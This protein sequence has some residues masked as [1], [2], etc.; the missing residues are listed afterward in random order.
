MKF[1]WF[2]NICILYIPVSLIGWIIMLV[3]IFLAIRVFLHID[4]RS[5]SAS[6][7]L[8]NFIF[9]LAIIVAVYSFVGFLTSKTKRK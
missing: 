1:P 3:G 7:T 9:W 5:H 8:I 2:K 6:D 4:S